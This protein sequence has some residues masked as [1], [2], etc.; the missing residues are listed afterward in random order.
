MIKKVAYVT[1]ARSEYGI[2]KRLLQRLQ[3][4]KDIEF[5]LIVT[6]MHLGSNYGNTYKIIEE[7]GLH[8]TKQINI[9]LNNDNNRDITK[10]I[11][12]AIDKFGEYFEIN[13]YDAVIL[14]GDRYEIFGVAIAAAMHNIPI[15]HLH[16]GEQTLGN[17]DEFIR[18]SITKMSRLHLVSTEQYKNRVIQLG[19]IPETVINVGSL[20]A[21][22]TLLLNIP[23][24]DVLKRKYNLSDKNYYVVLFHP[25]TLTKKDIK[26]QTLELL[27]ALEKFVV[28]YDF[29]FIGSNSDTGSGIIKTLI[30]DFIDKYKMKY[31]VSTTPEDYL[32][33]VKYSSGLIGNSSS[34]LIEIPTLKVPTINIGDRQKGRV[35]G[36]TVIDVSIDK[37]DIIKGILKSQDKEYINI[38]KNSKNPYYQNNVLDKICLEINKFLNKTDEIE[39]KEFY[40]ISIK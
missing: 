6:G 31:I 39:S 2:V 18:H 12:E 29:I 35:R 22:N 28:D 10:S 36:E 24:Y 11:G 15:I 19:E 14:L 8:I 38:C 25:E 23:N 5:S 17:Y 9:S 13:K 27:K 32:G 21:E 34:G 33:L 37:D 7:D 20:G 3:D 1:G 4:N 16:G 26:Q 30:L 40:D